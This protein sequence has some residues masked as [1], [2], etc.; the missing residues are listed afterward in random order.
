M[1]ERKLGRE[2]WIGE[3]LSLKSSGGRV[4]EGASAGKYSGKWKARCGLLS[5]KWDLK[6]QANPLILPQSSSQESC[7]GALEYPEY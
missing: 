5:Q 4:E 2:R 1:V 7:G 6:A 3:L